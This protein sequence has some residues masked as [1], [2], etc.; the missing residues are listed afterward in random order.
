MHL[1][2]IAGCPSVVLYSHASDPA[3]CAQRGPRV[4]ILRQP[5]L[6]ELGVEEV[7]AAVETCLPG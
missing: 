7:M 2:A 6:A 1:A 3:L 4:T 5:K